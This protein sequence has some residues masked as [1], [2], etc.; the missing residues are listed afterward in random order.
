MFAYGFF[1][2]TLYTSIYNK[3]YIVYIYVDTT[4][5]VSNEVRDKL[6]RQC[7]KD[8]SFSDY[9]SILLDKEYKKKK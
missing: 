2:Y 7:P 4:I 5:R 9:I 8:L 1:M 6:G 3:I